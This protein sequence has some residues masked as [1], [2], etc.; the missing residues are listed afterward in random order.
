MIESI[1]TATQA[2]LITACSVKAGEQKK[3][4]ADLR[5]HCDRDGERTI[6]KANHCGNETKSCYYQAL[7]AKKRRALILIAGLSFWDGAD[8]HSRWF[9]AIP[10]GSQM[11]NTLLL[12]MECEIKMTE[13]RSIR[14]AVLVL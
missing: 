8:T 14:E 5:L 4:L 3:V 12:L 1:Q 6:F 13:Q 2:L 11:V 7:L 10:G 9:Y